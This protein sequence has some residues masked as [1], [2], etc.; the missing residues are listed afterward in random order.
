MSALR[1]AMSHAALGWV[2]PELD[3]T[4]RQARNEIEYFA[5]EPSDTSRMRFCAGYLHQVQGTLRMVELYAPAMVAEELELLA[6]AVQAGEVADRDEACAMLMRGTVLL[7]DYLERL[8]NGHRDIPIVLL[9]LLN[10]IRATR[11]QPGLSESVLFAFDPQAGVATEAELDHARGSLSGRNRELLDTVGNAVKEELLRVK[12]AL[13]LHLRTGGEIAELQTQVNDLGSV[14]DTLGMMG[15]GVAR[16][17][18]VQQRDALARVVDGQTQMDE[19]VLLDIA[20]AL[21]YV[22]ASLDDQ[23]AS[24]GADPGDGTEVSNSANSSEVRRTV[25]VLAQEAIANFGAA[26]EHFVAF[27]ETN[28]D[29]ARLAEVPHLLGEV[30]GALRILELPQ[31]ADYLE[32]VRRYVDLELIGKQR[33][34]S[35]R[36]LDTLADAMASLEYYL[37]ALRE[38]RPGRE[39]ILD[40]TRNS[41]ETL[42]YWPL[43]SGQPSDLP[44]GADQPGSAAEP[45][46]AAAPPLQ[47][48][49]APQAANDAA[50]LPSLEWANETVVETPFAASV[51][52]DTGAAATDTVFSF[53]P[54]AAEETV[55][56]QSHVPFTVAP[57][58][59]S[60]DGA[61]APGDWHLETTEQAAPIATSAFDPVS[62]EQDGNETAQVSYTV[63]LSALE[64]QHAAEPVVAEDAP[65]QIQQIDL[66]GDD[67]QTDAPLDFIAENATRRA[68]TSIED[69]FSP[70]PSPPQELDDPFVEP[71]QE[72]QDVPS[73]AA[74][75][76]VAP[77]VQQ[78]VVSEFE[79]DDA[80]AAFLAQ[81]DAAAAQFDVERPQAPTLAA[82]AQPAQASSEP[83]SSERAQEAAD[84]GI[85]GGFGDSDIDDDIR[86]VFLEEFDEELVNLGQLLPVW[87]A[88]PTNPETLR[89][90]RRVFHTL[91]GS[92]RLVGASV[93]GEFSWKIESMLNRVLDNSR[94]ASPAVVSMVEL[95]YAVLPQFN[96]ALRDQGRISADLPEIQGIAE[97]V[98]A[99]EEVY[100]VPAA[101]A[102]VADAVA[103]PVATAGVFAASGGT[104][105]SVDSVLREIL[106]AEVA[107]HLDTVNGWLQ[108]SQAEPQLATE[109]LLRAV[110]TMSGAFAM[111]DVPEITLVTTP[112][113][114]YVKRLLAASVTPSA[115]GLEALTATA[116]A[117]A[118]T[119]TALRADAPL[120]PSFAPLTERLRALVDTLPEA[121]WPPQA[122]LDELDDVDAPGAT[123]DGSDASV[124]LTG[125]QDLSQYLDAGALPSDAPASMQDA[126][127]AQPQP[128]DAPIAVDELAEAEH[129]SALALDAPAPHAVDNAGHAA[130]HEDVHASAESVPA[131][132][133]D[134]L[135]PVAATGQLAESL[136]GDTAPDEEADR[137]PSQGI[138]AHDLPADEPLVEAEAWDATELQHAQ[139]APHAH[140]PGEHVAEHGE[141]SAEV[142]SSE[143]DADATSTHAD[144]IAVDEL[145]DAEAALGDAQTLAAADAEQAVDAQAQHVPAHDDQV[146]AGADE[147]VESIEALEA[148]HAD[149]ALADEANATT[150]EDRTPETAALDSAPSDQPGHEH[151][152]TQEHAGEQPAD[153][154][155]QHGDAAR[156][157]GGEPYA[158]QDRPLEEAAQLGDHA[159]AEAQTS[160]NR[161]MDSGDGASADAQQHV[162][163]QVPSDQY[164]EAG[165]Q[166]QTHAHFD[167]HAGDAEHAT[168]HQRIETAHSEAQHA[169]A[170][171]VAAEQAEAEHSEA[172]HADADRVDA[173]QADADVLPDHTVESVQAFE[174]AHAADQVEEAGDP[175]SDT[176]PE[177]RDTQTATSDDAA[178]ADAQAALDAFDV[179]DHADHAE[180]AEQ[181][182]SA[183]HAAHAEQAEAS[184]QAGADQHADEPEDTAAAAFSA[185][186]EDAAR[187]GAASNDIGAAFDAGPLNFDQLDGELVDIFVE[188]GRDLLDHCDGLIARMR[189]VPGDRDVL[190]GLQRDLHTLKGGAR[191]AGI[192]AIGDLGHAIESLLEAVAAN[193][194]D[195][196]RDDVRLFERGFDRLH[197]LLTRTGMHRAVTMPTDLVEAFETR[198]RGR[199]AAA[200]SDAD[201]RA[202]AKASVEP[203]PLSAPVPVEG[204]AEED[205]LPRAQQEQVRVRADLLD[206]LVNHAGEVAIYRSRLEQQLGAFRGAMGELDRTNARLRDQLRRLD[207]ETEAQIVARYQREQ[208]QGDRTFD[209][210][211]LDR[212]STLQ[213]LSRALN[214]SAADLGGLQGVLEDLSRQYDGLLQQQSRVSSELQDGLMRARMVPFDGLV[215]R[216][217]RVVR[218]AAS[219]TGKQVHLVLEGTQGELDRNVLDRMVA[220]LEHMLRNSVAHGLETPEQRRDAGK[221]EEGSI[222]IR[223][224][225]EGSEIVLEVADDGAGLDREAIRRRGEERG[226]IE[227]GQE[228][229]EAELDNLIFASGFSTSEQVSQLA[230]RGVGMDVVRNEVRQLG[231]SVDIHSVR[232]QGA[233]FTLRLPQTLAV[234]QAVFVRIGETT[235]AVPVGSVSGI[236]RIS[237]TRYESGEGGYH[238]AGEEY[239]LHDLGS[240]VGQPAARADGQAQVPLLLVRAGDLRAAVAIDQVLGNREVVVKPVG[241]QIASVPGI[242]GATITGDGRVVV[243]LDVAPL[244]RRFLA[245]PARPS[246]ETQA[247]AQRQVP[248]VMVVDDSL[249]MRKVTSRVL[250]RHNLDVSTARDGVEALELL[251]ERV[252]DLML[253]DIEMPRMDGYELA[254]AMRADPRFKA[255][256]IV[257]ITSRSGEKHRQRAFEI[258]VQR[259]LGKPYQELDLMR[260]VYDLLGIARVRD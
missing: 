212:F 179:V 69:A 56:G 140:A 208:D 99:G 73:E 31:A 252:P 66:P 7:P 87:R 17:V 186:V 115:D 128:D 119:V 175:Q 246:L 225:R 95:A 217:R 180:R 54:V 250:E 80:S 65:L 184:D 134:A 146:A 200:P 93:L 91:K 98:A 83:V 247:E 248:L 16:S 107:T 79:L 254:T 155:A 19:S 68:Q 152:D 13:D 166:L 189:E 161:Q 168:D 123:A 71:A 240:L 241:L 132:S 41:L 211:E 191:M 61:Q 255:V 103:I 122:F 239:V 256:P 84:A 62:A 165:E 187:A 188:E 195:I 117:I 100:Y 76:P 118:A 47:H 46:P 89:P 8:Q 14:A 48:A 35:G 153:E 215:P 257:M 190:N 63:D 160:S 185:P 142:V 22:D 136:H 138:D 113:E 90:I 196:D 133:D 88:A 82:D 137:A 104:P 182:E 243:I 207:L 131:S 249:T 173:A 226:L 97:R 230:G 158:G 75:E 177:L 183:E 149:A 209:P 202:I 194:T 193:R 59:L 148:V 234:T 1:D 223:L 172:E 12:D 108:A 60:D 141:A 259:Y 106:E 228:L 43:P 206:R 36:Q 6:Q 178:Q 27:I 58:D 203:A 181:F 5:E 49:D 260:N 130:V 11:G 167:E 157:H 64:Q 67:D 214:E 201:V 112:A 163:E 96:A 232:G 32:G 9:P 110:H 30:G 18:V 109:E 105:A 10:E 114:S 233:T 227:P 150:A 21:L 238:Y 51:V 245:Q 111:T 2:K 102:P 169:E 170:E 33:V 224:R 50:S 151:A 125:A 127:D 164:V 242:Y 220:P 78:A 143:H 139:T 174:M 85:F 198:T 258:G 210:L 25:D 45:Q 205:F 129:D 124:E 70:P 34:P 219:D 162:H 53:D 72:P 244:V 221:P 26:R 81:L 28:W 57:L 121:Q 40:I 92:G 156:L 74:S 77:R 253:L 15:L 159:E 218:Q 94:P 235:F 4:L 222:A 199:N 204:Q 236:G 38:R 192:N 120:I 116:A 213:Q 52:H 216:L 37:E 154:L 20:G 55:S 231:G 29:H 197:Q 176:A 42:R 44:V 126:E 86:D 24:L 135:V 251:E 39:E 23:V 144:G 147:A 101:A 229:S 237:R 145:A 171:H 3:E